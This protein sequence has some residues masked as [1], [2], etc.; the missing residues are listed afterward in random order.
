MTGV[1][2]NVAVVDAPMED[3]LRYAKSLPE[4]LAY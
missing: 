2:P 3:T 1:T 4:L